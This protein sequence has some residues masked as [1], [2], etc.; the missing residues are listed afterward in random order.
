MAESPWHPYVVPFFVWIL[1][2]TGLTFFTDPYP[3]VYPIVYA[4]QVVVVLALLWRYRRL[5]PE[6]NVKFHWLAVPT[7]VGLLVA[8]LYAGWL[9]TWLIP[10]FEPAVDAEGQRVLSWWERIRRDQGVGFFW[11]CLSLKFVGM[12]LVVPLFEELF[13]RALLLR[14]F[15]RRKTTL[16]GVAQIASDLP[17]VGER[18]ALS[19]YG[20]KALD[21]GPVLTEQFTR[22][23]VGAITVFAVSL[24]TL[25]FMLNHHPRDYLGCIACGV[26]WCLLLYWTNRGLVS[27]WHAGELPDGRVDPAASP[28]RPALGL[29]PVVWSHAITNALLWAWTLYRDYYATQGPDWR[30]L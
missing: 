25:I 4:V 27:A 8:W 23:P 18:I 1:G 11:L 19:D 3:W 7:G 15:H 28:R 5:T 21:A 14:A 12:V 2:L 16:L 17:V 29:G 6:L 13:T 10:W 30:F 9:T 22:T 24:S 26:V 20:R